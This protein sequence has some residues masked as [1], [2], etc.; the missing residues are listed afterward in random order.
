MVVNGLS[1]PA[2]LGRSAL[3]V[4]RFVGVTTK[5]PATV[6]A[7]RASLGSS[8]RED[9]RRIRVHGYEAR[10]ERDPAWVDTFCSR[11][12]LPSM[13]RRHGDR[14]IVHSRSQMRACLRADGEFVQVWAGDRCI[15]AGLQ[16]RSGNWLSL[17]CLGWIDGDEAWTRK[18][19]V[20][21][22]YWFRVQRAFE[23]GCTE[24]DFGGSPPFA[25]S[26]LVEYKAKWGG[27]VDAARTRG[28][29]DLLL[30]N[31]ACA[32]GSEL[33]AKHSFFVRQP[34]GSL[35]AHEAEKATRA[36]GPTEAS[37]GEK[38]SDPAKPVR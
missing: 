4:P 31:Q 5:L 37:C 8:A 12:H 18:R 22:I 25:E 32:G 2:E 28:P 13:R 16:R 6:E 10:F 1:L 19:C 30:V 23:L 9:L 29:M 7:F 24:L 35:M 26:G 34:D 3:T 17:H 14:T 38:L 15:A 20:A 36:A 27:K 11:Y 33:L 21:A